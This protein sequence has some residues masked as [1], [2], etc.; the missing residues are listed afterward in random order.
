M[1]T[2]DSIRDAVADITAQEVYTVA[3]AGV[4]VIS[5]IVKTSKLI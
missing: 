2:T 1:N 5:C 4:N 3:G